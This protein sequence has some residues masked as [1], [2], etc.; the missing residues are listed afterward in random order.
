MIWV[1]GRRSKQ[2]RVVP[3]VVTWHSMERRVGGGRIVGI[4]ALLVPGLAVRLA[5]IVVVGHAVEGEVS[6]SGWEGSAVKGGR[7]GRRST[8]PCL[9]RGLGYDKPS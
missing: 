4:I 6:P 8:G 7:L 3:R 5:A 2:T 9:T 1:G